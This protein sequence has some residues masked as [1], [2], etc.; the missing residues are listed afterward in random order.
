MGEPQKKN[1]GNLLGGVGAD[2]EFLRVLATHFDMTSK[3]VGKL[4]SVSNSTIQKSTH[5][6]KTTKYIVFFVVIYSHHPETIPSV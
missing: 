5:A 3:E 4:H 1:R 6:G 2:V